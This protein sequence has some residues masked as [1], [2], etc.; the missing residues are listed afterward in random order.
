MRI[1]KHI[2][3]LLLF[4]I[5][6]IFNGMTQNGNQS[7]TGILL[8]TFGTSYEDAGV[9]FKNI[10]EELKKS[11]PGMEVR[12]AYTSNIIRKK[13][14]KEGKHIDS[15]AE[16]LTKMAADGYTHI[17]VQS[18]HIIPGEEYENLEKT[19]V[20]FKHMP[21]NAKNVV[22]GSPLLYH[23]EDI[24]STVD[25][26]SD[27]LPLNIKKDEALLMMGHGTHHPANVYYAGT[28]HYL[29][30]KSQNHFL[31]TVEGSPELKD[32][33]PKLV[34]QQ[35][36]K[37]WLMPF[38][39]VAG[40]HAQNDMAGDEPESW[41]SQLEARGYKVEIIMK[42]L[43]EYDDIVAIWITHLKEIMNELEN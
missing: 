37:V 26:I 38:M 1:I 25:A 29:L 23:A 2:T 24:K 7:K 17:A 33:L 11:F 35:I 12:W 21:K 18:L 13:L 43:A 30:Q 8:V 40:D 6:L 10:E 9:A 36:K 19:V 15:P 31:A 16:A 41:K 34:K 39:S 42:G 4:L 3:L 20:A 32:V 28:Q 14:K 27:I 5:I 22:L